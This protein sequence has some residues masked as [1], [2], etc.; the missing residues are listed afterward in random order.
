MARSIPPSFLP[1]FLFFNFLGARRTCYNP[2]FGS[3]STKAA[4]NERGK[5]GVIGPRKGEGWGVSSDG[6]L[7]LADQSEHAGGPA[8][9]LPELRMRTLRHREV[10]ELP[11]VPQPGEGRVAGSVLLPP[12]CCTEGS[13]GATHRHLSFEGGA[14][15]SP[16]RG[17]EAPLDFG[18]IPSSSGL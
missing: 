9:L 11:R 10:T 17:R 3:S 14:N 7:L 12:N 4:T 16:G 15:P 8:L 5:G 2:S 13:P 6:A 1:P 18:V